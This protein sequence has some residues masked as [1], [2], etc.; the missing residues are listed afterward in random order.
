[1][2]QEVVPRYQ[3]PL[4]ATTQG[5]S[6]QQGGVQLGLGSRPSRDPAPTVRSKEQQ[7][8][9]ILTGG[10]P[11]GFLT[12]WAVVYVDVWGL[13]LFHSNTAETDEKQTSL[14]SSQDSSSASP[15][16]ICST[17]HSLFKRKG[18]VA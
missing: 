14:T 2:R 17:S 16:K 13:L 8:G 1:M 6:C 5:G 10:L 11:M 3:S 9:A 7:H 12:V 4:P 15:A 18:R